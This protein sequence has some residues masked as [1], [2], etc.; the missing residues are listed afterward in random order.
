MTT[1]NDQR[2]TISVAMSMKRELRY[3]DLC[4]EQAF[5]T[6]G[7]RSSSSTISKGPKQDTMSQ[8]LGAACRRRSPATMPGLNTGR[9]PPN[10]GMLYPADPP[11]IE[12]IVSVTRTAG[13][14]V[15]GQRPALIV[16]LARRA[17]YQ[18]S[19]LT[20]RV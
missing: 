10:K 18:R 17:T 9:A 4:Q 19:A 14:S 1:S 20:R 6:A 5:V 13:D 7:A 3:P 15:H 16:V 11:T 2:G 12:E 8:I